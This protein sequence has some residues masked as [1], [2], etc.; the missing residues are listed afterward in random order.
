LNATPASTCGFEG[1]RNQPRGLFLAVWKAAYG[2]I[3]NDESIIGKDNIRLDVSE[4]KYF[5]NRAEDPCWGVVAK[6]ALENYEIEYGAC[7]VSTKTGIKGPT[8][9][10][11]RTN[12]EV[13][14]V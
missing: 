12:T 10:E 5:V 4:A 3:T 7:P 2:Y 6:I 9:S 14:L 11:A 8:S 13:A 1:C